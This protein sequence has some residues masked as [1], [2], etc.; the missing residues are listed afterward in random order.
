MA[1][2][3]SPPH[4]AHTHPP[5]LKVIRYKMSIQAEMSERIITKFPKAKYKM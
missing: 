3:R 2:M 5:S 1:D 4:H